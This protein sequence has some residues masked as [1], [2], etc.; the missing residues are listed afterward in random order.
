MVDDTLAQLGGTTS[1]DGSLV[2]RGWGLTLPRRHIHS[3]LVR[4]LLLGPG[5]RGFGGQ[6]EEGAVGGK[7]WVVKW[8]C[9][10]GG[11]GVCSAPA[12][13]PLPPSVQIRA[14]E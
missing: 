12:L 9:R 8:A 5:N 4:S 2:G 13:V 7:S 3:V 10:V 11:P 14:D 6:L 1:L